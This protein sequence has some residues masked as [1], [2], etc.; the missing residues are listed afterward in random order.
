MNHVKNAPDSRISS[1]NII[2]NYEPSPKKSLKIY[3]L[4]DLLGRKSSNGL[5]SLYDIRD[6]QKCREKF[7]KSNL[8][9]VPILEV[10]TDQEWENPV[11]QD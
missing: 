4:F 9:T 3:K 2:G 7:P 8:F 11:Y 5:T 6:F 10:P 1:N